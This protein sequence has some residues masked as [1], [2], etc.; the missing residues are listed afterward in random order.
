MDGWMGGW[1]GLVRGCLT[2]KSKCLE[3]YLSQSDASPVE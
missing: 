1:F 3:E 2:G